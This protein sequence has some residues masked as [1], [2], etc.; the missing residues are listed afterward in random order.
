MLWHDISRILG[1]FFFCFAGSLLFPLGLSVYYEYFT[2]AFSHPQP[3][4]TMAFIES[5]A[6]CIVT[7]GILF[8][9][10]NQ[11]FTGRIY[12]REG[13]VL[14]VMIWFLTPV[15]ASLPFYL[16]GTLTNPTQAYFETVSGLTT[17]GASCMAAKQYDA[18]GEE[19]PIKKIWCAS[20]EEMYVY[21]GNIPPVKDSR[22]GEVIHEGV[23]AV[24]RAVLFWRSE[25]QWLGGMGIIFLFATIL[26]ALGV[27]GKVLFQSE[28]TGPMKNSLT[29]R[30]KETAA[31]LWKIYLGWT[32]LQ[33]ILLMWTNDQMPLFD[34]TNIAFSTISTGGF[35]I[36]NAS[37]GAYQNNA[38]DWIVIIF[39]IIGSVNFSLYFY[40]LSGKFFKLYDPE[41]F[42]YMAILGVACAIGFPLLVGTPQE[43]L[44]GVSKIFDWGDAIRIGVFQIVSANTSTGFA[45]A[46]YDKWPH[47]VQALLLIMMFVGGMSGSTA[48][49][50]KIIRHYMLFRIAQYRIESLFRPDTVRNFRIGDREI[51]NNSS[52][53][54]LCF[55]LTV[56][57]VAVLSTFIY[58]LIGI[59]PETA[60]GAVA[61]M[62]NNTGA[63]FKMAGPTESFAFLTNF[64][65]IFSSILMILGRLEYFAVL[66][67]LVPAFWK[68]K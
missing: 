67:I 38:T 40:V 57:S 56:I 32:V 39:M 21:W 1:L 45:V 17:T 35:S 53:L 22:T 13:L 25:L 11:K 18:E 63:A 31:H 61:C 51:D 58:I 64:G 29:P 43:L 8:W 6:F 49:G 68:Q 41:L 14:V 44:S 7:A 10:G 34:A 33:I 23:E 59:D 52:I 27:G 4:A 9:F 66:A 28:Q 12:R 15:L 19:V 62:L 36:K 65:M 55:F 30:L 20:P 54:V 60:L 50:I 26:P 16:S 47:A 37:I 5:I 24:S 48:G 2:S 3:H 46:N 42:L